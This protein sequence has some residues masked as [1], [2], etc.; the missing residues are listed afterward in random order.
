MS[1][2]LLLPGLR[3]TTQEMTASA[4]IV[5]EH[6][7]SRIELTATFLEGAIIVGLPDFSRAARIGYGHEWHYIAEKLNLAEPDARAVDVILRRLAIVLDLQ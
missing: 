1:A 7:A 4:H 5:A 3:I 2:D 6:Q